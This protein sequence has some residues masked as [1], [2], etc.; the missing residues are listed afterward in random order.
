M[1]IKATENNE[2][3]IE[4]AGQGSKTL[5]IVELNEDFM[6][7]TIN[8]VE[9]RVNNGTTEKIDVNKDGF[10]DL[11]LSLLEVSSSGAGRLMFKE[12]YEEVESSVQDEVEE[13]VKE[14]SDSEEEIKKKLKGLG[15]IS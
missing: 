9:V 15:Y 10:Y 12:I 14:E 4:F 6:E 2:I 3:K 5:E 7:I 13:E 8:A 1:A 11:E